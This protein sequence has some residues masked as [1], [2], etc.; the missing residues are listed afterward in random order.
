MNT[1]RYLIVKFIPDLFRNEPRNIG[2]IVWTPVGTAARFIAEKQQCLGDIDARCLPG[3]LTSAAAAYRQWISYWRHQLKE[4]LIQSA[5]SA[6]K[7]NVDSPAYLEVLKQSSK[8]NFQLMSGGEVLDPLPP[9][10]TPQDLADYLFKT[11]VDESFNDDPKDPDL[12]TVMDRIL[13]ESAI[14]NAPGFHN[15]YEVE[16]KLGSATDRF[17][18]SFAFQNGNLNLFQKVTL[19]RQLPKMEKNVH[20]TAWMFEQA[21]RADHISKENGFALIYV[22]PEQKAEAATDNAL[23]V[24]STVASVY[25]VFEQED[26][27]KQKLRTLVAHS[28]TAS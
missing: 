28:T 9:D 15:D 8:G 22:T 18:F 24:L 21:V 17:K 26:E 10:S 25:N 7:G 13:S 1:P 14:K 27:L 20:A 3:F 16:C 4:T 19:P 6:L 23:H 11:L 5:R 12:Q 2:V